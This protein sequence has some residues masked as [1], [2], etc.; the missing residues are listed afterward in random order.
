MIPGEE[1][2]KFALYQWTDLI[3]TFATATATAKPKIT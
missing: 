2:K 1:L 3:N